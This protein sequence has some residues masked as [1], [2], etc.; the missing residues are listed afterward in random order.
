MKIN[1]IWAPPPKTKELCLVVNWGS[2]WLQ[3]Y[4]GDSAWNLRRPW[5]V[6]IAASINNLALLSYEQ[7]TWAN[8]IK[9]LYLLHGELWCEINSLKTLWMKNYYKFQ[10]EVTPPLYSPTYLTLSFYFRLN[11]LKILCVCFF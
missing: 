5:F 11:L 1:Y 10:V 7:W 2:K 8:T 9:M 4:Q 3:C 6:K